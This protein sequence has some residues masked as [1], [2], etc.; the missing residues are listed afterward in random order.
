MKAS[1]AAFASTAVPGW[2]VAESWEKPGIPDKD[3][4]LTPEGQGTP[5]PSQPDETKSS[6]GQPVYQRVVTLTKLKPGEQETKPS[7]VV[8]DTQKLM[9]E[10]NL[11]ARVQSGEVVLRLVLGSPWKFDAKDR[12]WKKVRL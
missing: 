9:K 12:T 5:A 8:T 2:E 7:S 3:A 6:A 1:T 10:L 4:T 11:G